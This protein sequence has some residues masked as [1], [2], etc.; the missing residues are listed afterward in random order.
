VVFGSLICFFLYFSL[1]TDWNQ[2]MRC[3]SP[4]VLKKKR[5]STFSF[6][7]LQHLIVLRVGDVFFI[8]YLLS[9]TP[10]PQYSSVC[11]CLTID[12]F[13]WRTHLALS[14]LFLIFTFLSFNLFTLL[15][16]EP[17]KLVPAQ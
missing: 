6:T 17:D 2:Y 13:L 4:V 14:V 9:Q 3:R 10:S 16:N 8:L 11:S 7:Y 1:L 12:I 5:S 15:G